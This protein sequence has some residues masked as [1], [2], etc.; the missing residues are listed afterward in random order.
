MK[1][2]FALILIIIGLAAAIFLGSSLFDKL[3]YFLIAVFGL[4]FMLKPGKQ[5]QINKET[6]TPESA[7]I[8][9]K[10]HD[11]TENEKESYREALLQVKDITE[12]PSKWAAFIIFS[13]V[14]SIPVFL[15]KTMSTIPA[16]LVLSIAFVLAL[17][18]KELN[19]FAIRGNKFYQLIGGLAFV[20]VFTGA[21]FL[22]SVGESGKTFIPI[23][24]IQI[25]Y[26]Y[27]YF[28][29]FLTCIALATIGLVYFK[30]T[31]RNLYEALVYRENTTLTSSILF[32]R[33][34]LIAINIFSIFMIAYNVVLAI[35]FIQ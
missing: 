18:I 26:Y 1:K 33:G 12:N 25:G 24:W 10:E 27:L 29:S 28:L 11:F 35:L 7:N 15:S 17:F 4:F 16:L 34:Y 30:K 5:V 32:A 22:I 13:G 23:N 14:L 8:L 20:Y 2:V 19:I 3:S 31:K 21:G 9:F 6:V